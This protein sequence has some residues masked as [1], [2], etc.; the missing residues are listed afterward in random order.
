MG[1]GCAAHACCLHPAAPCLLACAPR[2]RTHPP[3]T[4]PRP[5]HTRVSSTV[6][7]LLHA[8]DLAACAPFAPLARALAAAVRARLGDLELTLNDPEATSALA[9]LPLHALVRLLRSGRTA[10][11]REES[12]VAAVNAWLAAR[13]GVAGVD[14]EARAW[15]RGGCNGGGLPLYLALTF[16]GRPRI[17]LFIPPPTAQTHPSDL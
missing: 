6:S 12:V 2:W 17:G 13:G 1:R 15:G 14:R 7:S 5:R 9:G 16:L 4:H 8:P 10:V 11:A 3:P